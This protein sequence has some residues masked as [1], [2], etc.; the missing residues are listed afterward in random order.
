MEKIIHSAEYFIGLVNTHKKSVSVSSDIDDCSVWVATS[1]YFT[2]Y[3]MKREPEFR[4]LAEA[5]F[6]NCVIHFYGSC[7]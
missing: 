2:V 4:I 6:C 3:S 5:V 7:Q 1:V